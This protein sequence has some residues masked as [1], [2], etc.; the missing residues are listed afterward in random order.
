ME[1]E[2]VIAGC[3]GGRA[4]SVARQVV[5]SERRALRVGV[6]LDVKL[7]EQDGGFQAVLERMRRNLEAGGHVCRFAGKC[8]SELNHDL[9]RIRRHVE[10]QTADAWGVMGGMDSPATRRRPYSK[11]SVI[12]ND[13]SADLSSRNGAGDSEGSAGEG[14]GDNVA[15]R[16]GEVGVDFGAKRHTPR[17]RYIGGEVIMAMLEV[18]WHSSRPTAYLS[19]TR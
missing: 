9:S 3:G 6:L 18:A 8:Q 14:A 1:G 7:E 13:Q 15:R 5:V 19:L 16:L 2:G 11:S 12:T 17:S 4:R 10:G